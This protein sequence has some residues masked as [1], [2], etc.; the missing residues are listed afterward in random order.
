MNMSKYFKTALKDTGKKVVM[1]NKANGKTK[2]APAGFSWTSFFFGPLVA[3]FRGDI[4]GFLAIVLINIAT[5][6]IHP[7]LQIST[8]W[9]IN[10]FYNYNYITRKINGGYNHL[11]KHSR[12]LLKKHGYDVKA[13]LHK[14]D[15][16]AE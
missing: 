9:L 7:V 3:L 12:K 1:F 2:A 15:K 14:E 11:S 10:I 8:V 6:C 16:D 5:G 4:L 13:L